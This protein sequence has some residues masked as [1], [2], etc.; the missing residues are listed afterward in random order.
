M[1][2]PQQFLSR[3][4]SYHPLYSAMSPELQ[5]EQSLYIGNAFSAIFFGKFNITT[6]TDTLRTNT[7]P[8]IGLALA[9]CIQSCY[10]LLKPGHRQ[11]RN[12]FYA[13]YCILLMVL[14]SIAMT[15][16]FILGQFMWINH[17]DVPDGPPGY[18]AAHVLDWYNTFGS[19]A[20]V[21]LVFTTDSLMVSVLYSIICIT[22]TRNTPYQLYRCYI[23]LGSRFLYIAVPALVLLASTGT[24]AIIALFIPY[25][26]HV[27]RPSSR[28]CVCCVQCR[29][30]TFPP[31][32][33]PCCIWDCLDIF[34]CGLQWNSDSFNLRQASLRPETDQSLDVTGQ[35][36]S[37]HRCDCHHNRIGSSVRCGWHYVCLCVQQTVTISRVLRAMGR[38][39]SQWN[40]PLRTLVS[41]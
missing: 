22:L 1:I 28:N 41:H 3:N 37:I 15:S 16:N 17:R 33:E 34:V 14:Y 25:T 29:A 9:L 21:A 11:L 38:L 5:F 2:K 18:F 26:T 36:S 13:L 30:P 6:F 10:Y 27:V 31:C 19:A 4:A 35:Q 8:H 32:W 24:F 39:R 7:A 20:S 12:Y 23:V 40:L